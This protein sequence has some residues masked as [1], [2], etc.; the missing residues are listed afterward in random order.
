MILAFTGFQPE[1]LDFLRGA[2]IDAFDARMLEAYRASVLD[3]DRG[4]ALEATASEAE[5]AGASVEGLG[6]RRVPAGF[7]P[8]HPRARLLRHNALHASFDEPLPSSLSTPSFVD[9]CLTRF[10]P[11]APLLDQVAEL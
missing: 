11:L 1:T 10:R 5:S 7:G 2:G 3:D 6:Y 8:V 9:H 4:T